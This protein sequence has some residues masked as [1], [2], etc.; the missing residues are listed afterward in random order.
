VIELLEPRLALSTYYVSPTGSDSGSGSQQSPWLTLQHASDQVVAGDTVDVEAGTYAGFVMGWD[1]PQSGTARAPITW[2]ASP[3]VVIDAPNSKTA[4]GIDL[5]SASYIVIKGFT[6]DNTTGAIT[7]AGIRSVQNTN[8]TITNNTAEQCGEWGIFSGFS[9]NL[10]ITNNV[11]AQ[12]QSQHGIYVSNTCSNP[13]I[14]GNTVW[15]NADCGIQLNGDKSQGGTGI[16]TGALIEDNII[17]NNGAAGGS[18]INCD[19]V[20]N[21]KIV[22]N[23]LYNNQASGISLYKIDGGGPSTNNLVV[24]NTIVN[25]SNSR[26][27]INIANASTGNT[28]YNNILYNYNSAHGSISISSNS[29]SN[30]TSDYNVVVNKFTA[31]G[32]TSTL[33]LA[34]WQA[35]T[36]Q[37]K[38]SIIATPSQLFVDP[39]NNNYQLPSTSPAVNAGTSTDAP[40]TDILGNSRPSGGAYDIGCYEYQFPASVRVAGSFQAPARDQA[41]AVIGIS[42]D[43][44][45]AP[46]TPLHRAH[47][48]DSGL[49][50]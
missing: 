18:A 40:S 22:N 39:S 1:F 26:W 33:T 49:R 6:V 45:D 24:N 23:L 15:G 9:N 20:Q 4:D 14:V 34:K 5:E 32:G 17:Y 31:N 8:V 38:H 19:G 21:S 16:I 2:S 29:L 48:S 10:T 42:F 46:I 35:K 13:V 11:A 3:G 27:D 41:A 50:S 30:F 37:D 43:Q 25:A 36:G 28:L 44:S 7:R 12:S 47:R